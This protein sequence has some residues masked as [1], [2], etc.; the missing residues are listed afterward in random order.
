MTDPFDL[1]LSDMTAGQLMGIIGSAP[2]R[3]VVNSYDELASIL[4]TSRSTI[5]RMRAEGLL[6]EAVSQYG[7]W[8]VIDVSVVLDKFRLSNRFK[9][10]RRRTA[11]G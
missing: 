5:Y 7:K 10:G 1:P 9:T 3:W 2:K 8:I 4:G 6:D 11:A